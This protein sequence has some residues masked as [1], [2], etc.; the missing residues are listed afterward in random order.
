LSIALD[1]LT[2]LPDLCFFFGGYTTGLPEFIVWE[3]RLN[4]AP[5]CA[6]TLFVMLQ[7]LFKIQSTLG[8]SSGQGGAFLP[9]R[10]QNMSEQ[11]DE[12]I[13]FGLAG[14]DPDCRIFLMHGVT[15]MVWL[16]SHH[17]LFTS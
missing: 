11:A 14:P 9:P 5:I 4:R 8:G 10:E 7:D 12:D 6:V 3:H 2:D 1:I 16:K 13:D 17:L 15:T